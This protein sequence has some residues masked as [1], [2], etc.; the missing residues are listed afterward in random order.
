LQRLLA[1]RAWQYGLGEQL[2]DL[3]NLPLLLLVLILIAAVKFF[4]RGHFQSGNHSNVVAYPCSYGSCT[5][6]TSIFAYGRCYSRGFLRIYVA[7]GNSSERGGIW[8]RLFAYP[9]YDTHGNMDEPFLNPAYKP[10]YI[11]PFAGIMGF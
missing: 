9:G 10:Y 11:L 3:K 5:K 7:R 1:N 2:T 8:L 6:C 4:D